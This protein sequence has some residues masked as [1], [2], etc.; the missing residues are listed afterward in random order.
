MLHL[1][2]D[3][4]S[5]TATLA[6]IHASF[7]AVAV[8]VYVVTAPS[9]LSDKLVTVVSAAVSFSNGAE[10]ILLY[11]FLSFAM[12]LRLKEPLIYCF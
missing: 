8:A 4:E 10:T 1:V 11:A 12:D 6:Q 9:F 7:V 3:A 2:S 5:V